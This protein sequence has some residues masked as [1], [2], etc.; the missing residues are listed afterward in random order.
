MA[1]VVMDAPKEGSVRYNAIREP[2]QEQRT[3]ENNATFAK[4]LQSLFDEYPPQDMFGW[5]G[6]NIRLDALQV[7]EADPE[8]PLDLGDPKQAAH[9]ACDSGVPNELILSAYTMLFL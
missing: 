2:I 4:I 5:R 6:K 8:N 3:D 7:L 9:L 1:Q